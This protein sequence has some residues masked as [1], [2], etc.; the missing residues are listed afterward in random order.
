MGEPLCHPAREPGVGCGELRWSGRGR[1]CGRHR[2]VA[3]T[4]SFLV[5]DEKRSM[6]REAASRDQSSQ[7]I[8]TSGLIS[9]SSG[10]LPVTDFTNT[11]G[12]P[13]RMAPYAILLP[14]GDQTPK[15]IADAGCGQPRR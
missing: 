14:S 13:F 8:S 2:E 10:P 9:S 11:P 6:M 7:C 5:L 12:L 4:G 1:A 3:N 15:R